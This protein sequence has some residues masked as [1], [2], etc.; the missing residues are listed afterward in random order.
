VWRDDAVDD[1][2]YHAVHHAVS[3]T[4]QRTRLAPPPRHPV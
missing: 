1:V 3:G 2:V 4:S